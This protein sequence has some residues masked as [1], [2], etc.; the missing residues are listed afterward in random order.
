MNKLIN[1]K[2]KLNN[3]KLY[4][5]NKISHSKNKVSKFLRF[6]GEMLSKRWGSKGIYRR[7]V[8]KIMGGVG[9]EAMG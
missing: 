9:K 1:K 3:K 4:K 7:G 6:L 2:H 8:I 5:Y